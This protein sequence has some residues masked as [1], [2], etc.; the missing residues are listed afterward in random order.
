MTDGPSTVSRLLC[1][2]W[3]WKQYSYYNATNVTV[4][5]CDTS[6]T[7][8]FTVTGMSKTSAQQPL[9]YWKQ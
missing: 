9:Q 4:V 1:S 8:K 6:M 7:I 5:Y 3:R 2:R